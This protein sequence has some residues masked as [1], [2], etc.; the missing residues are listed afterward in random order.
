MLSQEIK[1]AKK[2]EKLVVICFTVLAF[3]ITFILCFGIVNAIPQTSNQNSPISGEIDQYAFSRSIP[4]HMTIG[5]SYEILVFV[6]NTGKSPA[7]FLVLLTAPSEFIYP[8]YS[9]R[10]GALD[11]GESRRI[12]FL[13]TPSKPLLGEL[14]I[15]AELYHLTPPFTRLDSTTCSVSS[16]KRKFSTEDIKAMI[17]IAISVVVTLSL[18]C[19][20]KFGA[21]R[22][23]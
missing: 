11:G 6:K 3:L 5:G 19:K 9:V 18:F 22:K 23:T 13:L 16:I 15:T 2:S 17:I 14:N 10:V 1:M 12:K 20:K 4:Q 7:Y 8:R 21:K